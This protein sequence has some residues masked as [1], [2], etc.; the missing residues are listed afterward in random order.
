MV[1]IKL[2]VGDWYGGVSS[3]IDVIQFGHSNHAREQSELFLSFF[4]CVLSNYSNEK[5]EAIYDG[6]LELMYMSFLEILSAFQFTN[7]KTVW[8]HIC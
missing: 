5:G 7:D 1:I 3:F 2:R 8:Y 6:G 4:S